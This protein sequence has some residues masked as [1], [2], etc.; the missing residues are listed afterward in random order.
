[1][2]YDIWHWCIIVAPAA[3]LLN[4]EDMPDAEHIFDDD[5]NQ[6]NENLSRLRPIPSRQRPRRHP[7][8]HRHFPVARPPAGTGR[9]VPERAV[10]R[11]SR[12]AQRG[13]IAQ[14]L[15]TGGS[16]R[17]YQRLPAGRRQE[18]EG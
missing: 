5:D 9:T 11:V 6:R 7:R 18:P 1:M 15:A 14:T 13:R 10:A 8:G 17:G 16:A 3:G 2:A 4:D 12:E